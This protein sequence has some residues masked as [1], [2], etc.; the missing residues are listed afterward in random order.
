MEATAR[1]AIIRIECWHAVLLAAML[2]AFWRTTFIDPTALIAGGVFM[3]VNFFLLS[4]G[5]AWVLTPLASKGRIK[6]GIGLLVLK[7]LFFLALLATVFFRFHFDAIS[8][9]LG[10][11]TLI[12]AIV[13]EAV[14]RSLSLGA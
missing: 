14:R 6:V 9:A 3:G 5:I 7:I 11:S 1:K 10:F 12:V 4:F 2:L 8:F 13:V